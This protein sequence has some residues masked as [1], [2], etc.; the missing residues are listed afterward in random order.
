MPAFDGI[1]ASGLLYGRSLT[2]LFYAGASFVPQ[3]AEAEG[4]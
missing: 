2:D 3:S 1:T 4:F